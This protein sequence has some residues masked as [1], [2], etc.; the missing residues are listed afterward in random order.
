MSLVYSTVL[1]P[2]IYVQVFSPF[3]VWAGLIAYGV[4]PIVLCLFPL[5][6][7]L[8]DT[9]FGRYKTVTVSLYIILPP[10]ALLLLPEV[11]ILLGLIKSARNNDLIVQIERGAL[12][13]KLIF[14]GVGLAFFLMVVML[15]GFVGFNA[16][17]IQFGMDQLHDSPG[18]DQSLF[19]HWYMWLYYISVFLAK[20]G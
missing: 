4:I 10:M 8:A 14:S 12:F 16:N 5:A 6:G 19:I 20:L 1:N 3:A 15:V 17:V 11:P 2:N 13:M 18:E 9:K 7:F